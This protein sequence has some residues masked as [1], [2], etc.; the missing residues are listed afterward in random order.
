MA[1][2]KRPTEVQATEIVV[3]DVF[4]QLEGDRPMRAVSINRTDTAV[5]IQY[6]FADGDD[7]QEY[8]FS[9]IPETML[10]LAQ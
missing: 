6:K 7:P 9:C 10:L 8:T 1:Q 3:D 5:T 4:R 2:K